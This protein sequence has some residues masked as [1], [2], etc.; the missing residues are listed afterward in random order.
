MSHEPSK[1][2]KWTN[3]KL[4]YTVDEMIFI[5]NYFACIYIE[6]NSGGGL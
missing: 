6:A 2:K 1:A 3:K 4:I 5:Y